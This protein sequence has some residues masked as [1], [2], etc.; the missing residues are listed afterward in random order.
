MQFVRV[1]L[2]TLQMEKEFKMNTR[3]PYTRHITRLLM[4]A[5]TLGVPTASCHA[6]VEPELT[7]AV[8][9]KNVQKVQLLISNGANVNE[10]DEGAEQTP[11]M[12]AVQV[13]D[14]AL[15]QILLAHGAVVNAQDDFGK[16]ALMFAAE[17]DNTEI[18]RM[19]LRK[20]AD[21]EIPDAKSI[22]AKDIARAHGR[23]NMLKV[24]ARA[25]QAA[26]KSVAR[27]SRDTVVVKNN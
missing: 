13:Q 9:Q 25:N 24:S 26:S 12:R 19:L 6:S 7:M 5:L 18:V 16:T 4:I 1:R 11:L 10:T 27:S 17:K 23:L 22:T 14:S 15:V 8:R 2:P 21:V 3:I 20:G